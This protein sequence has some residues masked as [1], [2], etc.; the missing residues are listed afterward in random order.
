MAHPKLKRGN[1]FEAIMALTI[2]S[3]HFPKTGETGF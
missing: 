3:L 2:T 1:H